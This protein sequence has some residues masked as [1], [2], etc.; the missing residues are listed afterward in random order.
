MA[1]APHTEKISLAEAKDQRKQAELDAQL[2]ANRIAL[3]RQEDAKAR[4]KVEQLMQKTRTLDAIRERERKRQEFRLQQQAERE[5][6][7]LEIQQANAAQRERDKRARDEARRRQTEAKRRDVLRAKQEHALAAEQRRHYDE[8]QQEYNIQRSQQVRRE[9]QQSRERRRLEQQRRLEETHSNYDARVAEEERKREAFAAKVAELEREERELINRLQQ[10]HA[11]QQSVCQ[12][13]DAALSA[14]PRANSTRDKW[15]N[16]FGSEGP[17][18][19]SPPSA[20]KRSQAKIMRE[21]GS[22]GIKGYGSRIGEELAEQ[23]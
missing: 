14:T 6:Q 23:Q 9:Q 5:R 19:R 3:L 21:L 15:G 18:R 12:E 10:T 11:Q 8:E 7:V 13:L 17:Q 16:S 22:S 2:L 4:K 20:S 1:V